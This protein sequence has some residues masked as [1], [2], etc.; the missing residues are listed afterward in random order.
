MEL[1]IKS[2][3]FKNKAL[4]KRILCNKKDAMAAIALVI[5]YLLPI[6]AIRLVST[7]TGIISQ[8]TNA[9]N[10]MKNKATVSPPSKTS[11]IRKIAICSP[12]KP[13]MGV[14]TLHSLILIDLLPLLAKPTD[15]PNKS[16]KF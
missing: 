9:K 16:D 7:V 15:S 8:F 1:T 6:V 11:L 14:L 13:N 12:S 3:N 4:L 5:A 10:A 2:I